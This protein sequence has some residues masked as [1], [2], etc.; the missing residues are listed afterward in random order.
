MVDFSLWF[1]VPVMLATL[2][3]FVVAGAMIY[4]VCEIIGERM[5]FLQRTRRG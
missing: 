3:T 4:S 2:L 5:L 1:L